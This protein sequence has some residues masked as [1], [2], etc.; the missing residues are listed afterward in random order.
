MTTQD[1]WQYIKNKYGFGNQPGDWRVWGLSLLA[2]MIGITI[3]FLSYSLARHKKIVAHLR[4]HV[5]SQDASL[6][7][8]H[9]HNKSLRVRLQLSQLRKQDSKEKKKREKLKKE[10]KGTLDKLE[11]AKRKADK[12]EKE[13]GGMGREELLRQAKQLEKDIF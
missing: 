9:A 3:F 11:T 5:L 6:Q 2:L 10:L 8:A 12:K 1:L 13:L 7:E 4:A